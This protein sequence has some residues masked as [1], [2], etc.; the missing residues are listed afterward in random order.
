MSLSDYQMGFPGGSVVKRLTA[1]AGDKSLV[2][3]LGRPPAEGNGNSLQY[4]CLGNSVDREAWWTMVHGVAKSRT[5]LSMSTSDPLCFLIRQEILHF[6]PES[7]DQ[8]ITGVTAPWSLVSIQGETA[9]E[10]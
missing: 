1:N 7:R 2:P 6:S 10:I 9:R 8:D 3:G 4:S 5:R